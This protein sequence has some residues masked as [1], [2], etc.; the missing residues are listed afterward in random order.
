VFLQGTYPL[1]TLNLE[2]VGSFA[3][4][5]AHKGSQSYFGHGLHL[6]KKERLVLSRF[7]FLP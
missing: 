6:L 1:Q 5:I 2:I 4:G 7:L 3:V